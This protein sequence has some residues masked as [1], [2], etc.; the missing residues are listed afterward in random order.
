VV[1]GISVRRLVPGI[2]IAM[3]KLSLKEMPTSLT[4]VIQLSYLPTP[5]NNNSGIEI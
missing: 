1:K 3:F 2:A 4:Y 5:Q